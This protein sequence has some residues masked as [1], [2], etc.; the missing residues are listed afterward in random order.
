MSYTPGYGPINGINRMSGGA[1]AKVPSLLHSMRESLHISP[2]VNSGAYFKSRWDKLFNMN[3]IRLMEIFEILQYGTLYLG[4]TFFAGVGLDYLFPKYDKEKATRT[5]LAE[6]VLQCLLLI[7][8][9]F[10]VRK[11]VKLV[12]F[13]FVVNFDLDGDGKV[14]FYRPYESTEYMGE[15]MM[16]VIFISVQLNLLRKVNELS[17]RLYTWL[18]KEDPGLSG[19][20]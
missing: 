5:I 7:L 17:A 19:R 11:L 12:P 10:F 3:E 16:S 9:A 18:Y 15:M 1:A 2:D 4:F 14:P 6:V 8:S 20:L 13:L